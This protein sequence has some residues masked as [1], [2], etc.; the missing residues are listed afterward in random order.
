MATINIA[1]FFARI[2]KQALLARTVVVAAAFCL[3]TTTAWAAD[4]G[5]IDLANVPGGNLTYD[6]W[7]FDNTTNVYTILDGANVTVTGTNA[8]QRRL[9]VAANATATITL[10]DVTIAGLGNN[11]SPLLLNGGA[12][13]TLN[14]ADGTTNT[15]TAGPGSA[16]IQVP[17][18]NTL[19]IEGPGTLNATG[20]SAGIGGGSGSNAYSGSIIINGGT[21]TATGGQYA[22]GIGGG[23]YRDGGTVTINGGTVTAVGA[24]NTKGDIAAGNST[25][26][27]IVIIIKGGTVNGRLQG[28]PTNGEGKPVYLNT[29]TVGSDANAN[30]AITAGHIAGI[31]CAATPNAASGVY[32][33]NG[34]KTD[35]DG[36]V[37]FYLPQSDGA[38]V[39]RLTA[40][41]TEYGN[42]YSRNT[43]AQT[44]TLT[45]GYLASKTP[46]TFTAAEAGG[47][48]N[49]VSSTGI[50]L[51]FS[52]SVSGLTADNITLTNGTGVAVKGML[53]GSG[54]T[55]TLS[56]TSVTAAGDVKVGVSDFGNY[57]V[58]N[59]NRTVS[60]FRET[61]KPTVSG[62]SPT[63]ADIPL[64]TT[65][66]VTFNEE[67]DV[68]TTG[69]V[70]L[71]PNTGLTLTFDNWTNGNTTANYTLSGLAYGAT[72]TY[73]TISGFKD[74]SGNQMDTRNNGFTF[75]TSS[76]F[77]VTASGT[78]DYTNKVLT[79]GN[80]SYTI[81]LKTGVVSTDSYIIVPTNATATITLSDVTIAG[82]GNNQSPLLLNGGANVTLNLAD[83]T[84][85]TLTAGPGSAGIQV[86]SGNTL[87]IEGPGT[88]N[89]TGGSAG[90]GGGSGS[91]AYSGSIIINGGTVTA[92]GGQYAAG[93][94]GGQY[95]D[96]GT[97]TINGGT[98]TAVGASNTKGDIAAG[99]GTASGIVIIIKGGTVNGRLQGQPTNG[100]GKPVYLN[101]LTVGSDANADT[102]ITAGH[103]AG[104]A[105]DETPNAADG[106]YGINGVQTDGDGKV[107]FYLPQSDGAE[108]VRLTANGTEYGNRYSRNTAAQTETLTAN[109]FPGK[110]LVS[111]TA[112]EVGGTA[113]TM[114]STGITLTF[115]ESVSGLTADNITLTN[116]TGVAVKGMLTGSGA[117]Y[118]LNL[119]SVTTA[120]TVKVDIEGFDNY[121]VENGNRTVSLY[122]G[123]HLV[124]TKTTGSEDFT[125][126]DKV[127]TLGNGT[128]DISL[129]AGLSQTD[130][131]I[132]VDGKTATVTLN[133][134]TIAGLGADQSPLLLNNGANVT[135]VLADGKTNTLTA[136]GLCAGIQVQTGNT[137]T[138]EGPGTLSATGGSSSSNTVYGGSGIGGR[139]ENIGGTITING[140]TITAKG[141]NNSSGIG[142]G[143]SHNGGITTITGGTVNA[144]G[145]GGGAGI[146]GGYYGQ[147]G[148][149]T[150]TGGTVTAS[151]IGPGSSAVTY[152]LTITGGSIQTPS[153]LSVNNG[154][155]NG[156]T[157]Y[158]NTLTLDGLNA[159][160]AVT[161]GAINGVACDV[162]PDAENGVYGISGVKTDANGVVYLYLPRSGDNGA[163]ADPVR[164]EAN[165]VQ[166]GAKY[167]RTGAA[168]QTLANL[169]GKT[170]VTFTAAA[171]GG[172]S[173]T[174]NSTGVALTFSDNVTT[175]AG[176]VSLPSTNA[177]AGST[178]TGSGNVW[179]VPLTAVAAAG[180]AK[181]TVAD[182][183][184]YWFDNG[185][186]PVSLFKDALNPTV[187]SVSP[188]TT[189]V[190]VSTNTLSVTFSEEMDVTPGT[191][192]LTPNAGLTLTFSSWSNGNKTANYTLSGLAYGTTYTYAISA[193]KDKAN[194]V[195]NAVTVANNITF[196][197]PVTITG[198][199]T[200]V[201]YGDDSFIGNTIDL[202]A[203][204]LFTVDANAG[205]R[206]YTRETAGT[207][208]TG[209]INSSSGVLTVTAAGTFTIGLATAASSNYA[210]HSKVTAVLTVN[211][212]A[213]TNIGGSATAYTT[214]SIDLSAL[215]SLFTVGSGAGARTYSIESGG[216][217]TGSINSDNKTLNV[218]AAGTFN[219][220]LATAATNTHAASTATATLTTLAP[221]A[222]SGVTSPV[223]GET[224]STTISNGTGFTAALA[225]NTTPTVFGGNTVY[226]ATIT[227]TATNGYEFAASLNS[228]TAISGFKV[229]GIDPTYVS[230][231][232]T[233]LKFTVAFPATDGA[234]VVVATSGT[235]DYTGKVLTLGNGTYDISLRT[236][237][238]QTDHR[239]IVDG[240]TATVT[241]TDV[242]MTGAVGYEAMFQL[243][244]NATVT[245][246]LAGSDTLKNTL[247]GSPLRIGGAALGVPEGSSITI[248]GNGSLHAEDND[249]S[250]AIGGNSD[251]TV[252]EK[253]GNITIT[254]NVTVTAAAPFRGPAI[255]SGSNDAELG[256]DISILAGTIPGYPKVTLSNLRDSPIIGSGSTAAIGDK[257]I[258][259]TGGT[260]T[261]AATSTAWHPYIGTRE[262]T[263]SGT[264]EISGGTVTG[265]TRIYAQNV[266]I[267]GGS[268]NATTI[269]TVP[270]NAASGGVNVYRN[271]LTV[272]SPSVPN[273]AI[274]AG[275][276]AGV[277]CAETPN[278]ADGVYGIRDVETDDTGKV[279]FF[280]PASSGEETVRLTA[281]GTEYGNRY[282]RTAG[283]QT[284]TLTVNGA[285]FDIP[286]DASRSVSEY[287]P[288]ADV[289]FHENSQLTGIPAGGLPVSGKVIYKRTFAPLQWH[290]IGFPFPV[291]DVYVDAFK[292]DPDGGH[293]VAWSGA[294]GDYLLKEYLGEADFRFTQTWTAGKGYII[295]FPSDF[296]DKEVSFISTENPT[297][298]NTANPVPGISTGYSL[299][300]NPSVANTNTT[301]AGGGITGAEHYYVFGLEKENH[302]GLF[303][304]EASFALK[305]FEAVIV[306]KGVT[307]LRSSIAV[308]A[309]I[310]TQ[311]PSL[312]NR[313]SLEPPRYYNLQGIEIK[314]LQKGNVYIVRQGGVTKKIVY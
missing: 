312:E 220:R 255:G 20:G 80:G 219:I 191:V 201:T 10:S 118:T 124:V 213:V 252:G 103:I 19:T 98:V 105:C 282:S 207:T 256:G 265:F 236:G 176:N 25:A 108:V 163:D 185:P 96:G 115:S 181:V 223:V 116:G 32:G 57:L 7:T 135:L 30:T 112:A 36:K 272:G 17:S 299:I 110:T 64:S 142:G 121:L 276:I 292:D 179:T 239:I 131:R 304:I 13:V 247:R 71:S 279:Y 228:T 148:N 104:I 144:S 168:T 218:T 226:T 307:Q 99:N 289:V 136:S 158:L 46:V 266:V 284:R 82:L 245:L 11:Q 258:R 280:L 123:R 147:G 141:G 216:T 237:L 160:H 170:L 281:D 12:N 205:T 296:Q 169:T 29:L 278:A 132:I 261:V 310:A 28:Q 49:T 159:A 173:G 78:Y 300:A 182:Y 313:E 305:P 150:I 188:N 59:G 203:L 273:A 175:P 187:T 174:A 151:T 306:T 263:A 240:A 134:V 172:A 35:T 264:V 119:T 133:G 267:T 114:S 186:R 301:Q 227:L 51:T 303:D 26:S 31:D 241:L 3:S 84:T 5:T 311:I 268:V 271:V 56:L 309:D 243:K 67:M 286:A 74:K 50:T 314:T 210:A 259:I 1:G 86:P 92:T 232:A 162:T 297:L 100:E 68:T 90:I 53:T 109:A 184:P 233:E 195:M 167:R 211:K 230:R 88:L 197:T 97:V 183:D 295:Q 274:T 166:Y 93:I 200:E 79:L 164:L 8:N 95:R 153:P 54:A 156:Q 72:Y 52:E 40:N 122:A 285:L 77:A 91:N 254:G 287:S 23:Q 234:F 41:G 9:A 192:T 34:V 277:A 204:G 106:V 194:N 137:L 69:T 275:H 225:W 249:C 117:T 139:S 260:V 190:L 257:T 75:A 39:V 138:I 126:I 55:Y 238:S 37:Y 101:T 66:S 246:N 38:E 81:S 113:N 298:Y 145:S 189:G 6:D 212:A 4:G 214:G 33:I 94:G 21:V 146:G 130:N 288:G 208:G 58:E 47:T 235:Y 18:G 293:V 209:N 107:Y 48:A 291:S 251:N 157:V 283:A 27:G 128:Y 2:I 61:I 62:V 14:L 202:A 262:N 111:Y 161:A 177:T 308:D 22:A 15:L 73:A 43:A 229:N 178:A 42:R 89:A 125:Y 302:F 65:L 269:S 180:T 253:C 198:N 250:A 165:G 70:T 120:G 244:N 290:T 193:F 221:A 217:G 199:P 215:S 224:P 242:N 129:L 231:S 24:S 85:N 248:Q 206:T 44:E 143:Y 127:L 196:S 149:I 63:G 60:L 270:K 83:G 140:G 16:G 222:I 87:T 155:G 45:A 76:P 154:N 171:Q 294:T 102:P 152:S